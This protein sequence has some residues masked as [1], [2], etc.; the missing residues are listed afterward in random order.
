MQSALGANQKVGMRWAWRW[1]RCRW[2]TPTL[3]GNAKVAKCGLARE[4]RAGTIRM[5]VARR[6][7]PS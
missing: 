2:R 7:A 4:V 6:G 5:I 3:L 1:D